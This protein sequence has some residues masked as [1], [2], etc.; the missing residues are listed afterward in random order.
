[1]VRELLSATMQPSSHLFSLS[2][3]LSKYLVSIDDQWLK[4][5]QDLH[6]ILEVDVSECLQQLPGY[7]KFK[8][9]TML[10]R[11]AMHNLPREELQNEN[12]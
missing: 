12:W 4:M 8:V 1:M 10:S 7:S 3:S 5:T 2:H 6:S 11:D 9:T